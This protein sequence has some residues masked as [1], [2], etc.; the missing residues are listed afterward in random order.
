MKALNGIRVSRA[1]I[2]I[3]KEAFSERSLKLLANAGEGKAI[4]G[5]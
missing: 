3:R 4:R 5:A 2:R 1:S